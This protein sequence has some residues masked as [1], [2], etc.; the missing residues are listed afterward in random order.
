[1][2]GNFLRTGRRNFE[3]Q[4]LTEQSYPWYMAALQTTTYGRYEE[5]PQINRKKIAPPPILISGDANARAEV[6]AQE[7]AMIAILTVC[8][9]VSSSILIVAFAWNRIRGV[10]I[11]AIMPPGRRSAA[12]FAGGPFSF[13]IAI[14]L[15]IILTLVVA[16]HETRA[17]ELLI[18]KLDAGSIHPPEAFE[19]LEFTDPPMP[20][21][22]TKSPDDSPK[23]VD[24]NKVLGE[25][26][27]DLAATPSVTGLDIGPRHFGDYLNI[28]PGLGGNGGGTFPWYIT[29]LR[30]KG[31]D[32][33]LVIDGTKS[34]DFVMA[35][36]K[37]RM[38]RLAIRVRQLVPIAR[39]GVVV[40]GGKGEPLDMQPLTLSTAKL[41]TFLG[42]IQAKGG[43]EWQENTLGAVQAAV[44]KMDWKPY[45]RKVIVLIGDSPPEPQ[46]FAP[47]LALIK[48]FRRNNGTLSG[49]DVQQEE[50]ERFAR[51]FWIKVHG[52][53]PT[54]AEIGPLPQFAKQAQAAYKV[55]AATGGGS[56]RSLSHD[57]E[58]N[59]QVMILVFGDKWQDE[60]SRFASR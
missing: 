6:G 56:I 50:H 2:A 12:R 30:H 20:E 40:F 53:E 36:V 41:Q 24:V 48:D 32:I 21:L 11:S 7:D 59:Q 4:F 28:H 45:A 19:P 9:A 42:S 54:D 55:L 29:E 25:N 57:A 37:A 8:L 38:T 60:V 23:P 27:S 47:L 17:R 58:I 49:V 39:I 31:L 22:K 52:Q 16:V 3:K 10:P 35:D 34:M 14:H 46:D 5:L 15:A 44:A 18:L 26:S 51:A 13:S 33:V 43:G 1:V